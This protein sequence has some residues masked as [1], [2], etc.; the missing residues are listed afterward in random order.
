MDSK[1]VYQPEHH[2][3]LFD[4]SGEPKKIPRTINDY[5]QISLV[6]LEEAVGPL[7]VF[8][9]QVEDMV[10][11]VKEKCQQ[12]KDNLSIDES[13]SIMLYTLEWTPKEESFYYICNRKLD[14][15]DHQQLIPWY[16]YLKLIST[17][18]SK[19]PTLSNRIFYRGI[20]LDLESNYPLGKIFFWYGFSSCTSSLE[21]LDK[22]E[23]CFGQT[24]I[25]TLFIIHSNQGKNINQHSFYKTKNEILLPPGQSFEVVSY[26]VSNDD[27]HI[28][29]LKEFSYSNSIQSIST[30]GINNRHDKSI[31]LSFRKRIKKYS[32]MNFRNQN[33]TDRHIEIIVKEAID[34]KNCTWLSLQNN[35]ITSHG[36]SIIADGLKMYKSLESLYLSQNFVTDTGVQCL[37]KILK[38]NYSNL[39]LLSLDHNRIKD[40]GAQYLATMLKTNRI[41]T[42]LWLS[43]N[44]IGDHGLQSLV[45]VLTF[46][47]RTLMQLYLHGNILITDSNIDS[48]VHMLTYNKTLNTLWLQ[49]CSL[50]QEGKEKLEETVK[51]MEYFD[52]Y[53]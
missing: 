20:K 51:Y 49:N 16:F 35:Q 3:R 42:D 33:L 21:S 34:R 26:R 31:D 46:H 38:N 18:L 12:P 28:I 1:L 11:L 4:L 24:G 15:N 40:G 53:V 2:F 41:L 17:S 13:A 27:L 52:L 9:P 7:V 25:R 22:D 6:T 23:F 29:V 45:N 48:L 14:S 39:T 8:V 47:N 19:L 37:T 5:E 30:S 43:Y 32:E 44:E 36:V 10:K 50:S